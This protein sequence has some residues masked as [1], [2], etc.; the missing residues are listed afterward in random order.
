MTV[1]TIKRWHAMGRARERCGLRLSETELVSIE[2]RVRDCGE[3]VSD[4]RGAKVLYC[5]SHKG[6][7][8]FPIYDHEYRC[9]VTF[10]RPSWAAKRWLA[11]I[12]E[13]P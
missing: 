8:L 3:Y 7:S 6:R 4:A 5:V 9:I 11:E 1:V 13:C 12:L 2:R 10:L